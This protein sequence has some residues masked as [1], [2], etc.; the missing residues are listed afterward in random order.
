MVGIPGGECVPWGRPG[1]AIQPWDMPLPTTP[2]LI[3]SDLGLLDRPEASSRR[4]WLCFGCRLK[5]AGITPFVMA[6]IS[7]GHVD[8]ELSSY[9]HI[10]LW[11][12]NSHLRRQYQRSDEV[13]QTQVTWL[14]T[15]LSPTVRIEP[16]LL[17]AVRHLLPADEVD[18]GCEA[19]FWLHPDVHVSPLACAIR[20]EE[21]ILGR[22][23]NAFGQ[24]AKHLQRQVI[25]LL[26]LHHA[27]LFPAIRHEETLIWASLVAPDLRAEFR[28]EI[29]EAEQFMFKMARMLYDEPDALGQAYGLRHQ[30]RSHTRLRSLH[31]YYSMV[32]TVVNRDNIENGIPLRAGID[33]GEL[34]R[35]LSV[36]SQ[37]FRYCTLYQRGNELILAEQAQAAT[38]DTR[39]GSRYAD[40]A[41]I[42]DSIF[43]EHTSDD[44]P[45]FENFLQ[46]TELP[47]RLAILQQF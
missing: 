14:L 2:V 27:H 26:R 38:G 16:A 6:P 9:F 44:V 7:H 30:D 45:A 12:T 35:S 1:Q 37:Q 17:R 32:E 39:A 29:H 33:R 34:Q 18:A 46:L 19:E 3:F 13:Q 15:L 8:P 31:L 20:D 23:R 41:L 22:H 43:V 28:K 36:N 42:G 4:Q 47:K 25:L 24:Q 10:V 40:V 21:E 5:A 11:S